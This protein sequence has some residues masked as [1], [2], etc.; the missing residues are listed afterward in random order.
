MSQ[1]QITTP[2]NWQFSGE[3]IYQ[4]VSALLREIMLHCQQG[5]LPQSVDLQAVSRADSAG[6]ALL[7]ELV[8]QAHLAGKAIKFSNPS[9]QVISMAQ[10]SGVAELLNS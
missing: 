5:S 2:Q 8:R 7:I 3:L 1:L 10:V 4:T 6:I 9:P